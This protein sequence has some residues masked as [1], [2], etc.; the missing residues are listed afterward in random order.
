MTLCSSVFCSNIDDF[1]L[2]H[3]VFFGLICII[4][5]NLSLGIFIVV[6]INITLFTLAISLFDFT[7]I[8]FPIVYIHFLMTFCF[9]GTLCN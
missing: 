5:L 8:L 9:T 1:H 4:C 2:F 6:F 3:C 7:F